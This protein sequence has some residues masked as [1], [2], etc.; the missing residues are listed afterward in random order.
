MPPVYEPGASTKPVK[1]RWTG[2]CEFP[3]TEEYKRGHAATFGEKADRY[4]E[5]C[6]RLR[7]V[8]CECPVCR[9]CGQRHASTQADLPGGPTLGTCPMIPPGM[10]VAVP[11]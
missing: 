9:Y 8:W 5:G 11:T 2:K 7:G 4:C 1:R 10:M 6:G 3:L